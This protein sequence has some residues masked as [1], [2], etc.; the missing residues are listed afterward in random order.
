M[1]LDLFFWSHENDA[2]DAETMQLLIGYL[3]PIIMTLF[4]HDSWDAVTRP[5]IRLMQLCLIRVT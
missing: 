5:N 1:V 2:L 4:Y 3:V